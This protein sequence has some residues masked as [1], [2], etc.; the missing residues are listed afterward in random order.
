MAR[1]TVGN[2][3]GMGNR[4]TEQYDSIEFN[5]KPK[6]RK[7]KRR[8]VKSFLSL[9]FICFVLVLTYIIVSLLHP[10]GVIEYVKSEYNLS[11]YGSGYDISLTSGKPIYSVGD[12]DKYFVVSSS[13]I[14]CFNK[15]GKSVFSNSHSYS[16]PIIKFSETRYLL[17]NQGERTLNVCDFSKT[18]STLNLSGGII[19]AAISD[20]GVYAVASKSDG[21]ASSVCVYNKKHNKIY[22]W[23]SSDESVNSIAVSNNGSSIAISTIKVVNGKYLSNFYVLKFDSANAYFKKS[24]PDDVIY[25]IYPTQSNTFC[26]IMS[27]NIEFINYKK[28]LISSNES[29]Y[30]V[31]IIKC[32]NGNIVAVRTIAANQEESL[33]EV[34]KPNGKI[35]S[36]FKVDKYINDLSYYHNK[37]LL[38]GLHEI[39]KYNLS[40]EL[41][42]SDKADFDTIF[43]EAI[44]ENSVACIKNSAINKLILK[45][46]EDK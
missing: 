17:Y 44:S 30:S 39:F 14:N 45:P 12:S 24:Y 5:P 19:C 25:Q 35:I 8:S 2:Q 11:G 42:S 33:V 32:F 7:Q 27:N 28:E 21:Y 46:L 31:N 41:L 26:V 22:E 37:V 10:I 23:F 20:S 29:E 40:G 6:K 38:L 13:T 36:S 4:R 43:I 16:N 18:L 9:V 3:K 34:Y 15:N 1:R